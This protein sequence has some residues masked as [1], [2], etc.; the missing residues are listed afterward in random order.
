MDISKIQLR[1]SIILDSLFIFIIALSI[2]A[3]DN[4]IMHTL[5][6]LCIAIFALW[7]AIIA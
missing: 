6:Q 7:I 2:H 4:S 1:I 3:I 5:I